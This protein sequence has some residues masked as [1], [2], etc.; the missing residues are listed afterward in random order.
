MSG[1]SAE[2]L[3]KDRNNFGKYSLKPVSISCVKPNVK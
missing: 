3:T 1:K 2:E